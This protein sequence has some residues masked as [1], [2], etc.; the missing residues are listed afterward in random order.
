MLKSAKKQS[1]AFS[2]VG[3]NFRAEYIINGIDSEIDENGEDG[4]EF[5]NGEMLFL[6]FAFQPTKNL[7][8]D[9]TINLLGNV[10]DSDFEF[11]YGDRG[12]PTTVQSTT[13]NEFGFTV[14]TDVTVE[15]RER[16]EI[17]DFQAIYETVNFDLL[18]FYH[19]PR[20]HWG[21]EGDFY[22]LLRE[23]T[24]LTGEN[25][26]DIWNAK[27]PY[28]VEYIGKQ[29]LQGL[30]I[31]LGPEV[32]WGANPKAIVKY[33]FGSDG[34][35][36]AFMHS[37]DIARRDDSSS[38]TEATERQTRQTTFYA[39]TDVTKGVTVEIG[40]IYAGS[41]KVGESYDRVEN[42]NI[43]VDQI[44]DKDTLGVKGKVSFDMFAASRAYIAFNYAGLVA[45]GGEPLTEFGTELPYSEFGNKKEV[46]TGILI[47]LDPFTIYPRLLYRENLVDANPSIE[48]STTGT[49]LSPG[50]SP[51]NR[52]DDPFAVLDNREARSAEIYLTYDP[53]PAT[54]FYDWDNDLREDAE[55][56]FNIGLTVTEYTT[57]TDSEL[58]FFQEGN[59]NAAFGEGL[60]E[61]DVWLLKSKWVFNPSTDLK[62][63]AKAELGK[64]QPTGTPVGGNAEFSSLEGKLIFSRKHI[65]SAYV[66]KDDWGPYD[67]E[68]QF[69]IIYPEQYKFDYSMLL[70]SLRSEENSSK[71]GVKV[72]YRTLDERSNNAYYQDGENDYM[73]EIQTYLRLSF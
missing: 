33:E 53:T 28:G 17:Y 47:N 20:Y 14:T 34:V 56:A 51:R 29:S 60:P 21:Y 71:F 8:G 32:Y 24:D 7:R 16:I 68:R 11:R 38:A 43:V 58:F 67:F 13:V 72:L 10:A 50:I 73:F 31:V 41:E 9:F 5:D 46:D 48:P 66:K 27:A 6:D 55:L 42:G 57:A 39:K 59:T 63:I 70:D 61:E 25:G 26:Q 15:D 40:G 35:S 2:L 64:Q 18:S 23:T 30:K 44:E 62:V 65:I 37:E 4:L 54:G 1:D 45:D 19:V 12:L 22:G 69:N 52:D 36:Y 49:T 3:G